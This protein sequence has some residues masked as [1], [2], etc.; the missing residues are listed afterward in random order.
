MSNFTR[1]THVVR[2]FDDD[3]AQFVDVEVLDAIAFRID[4]G[5][6]VVLSMEQSNSQPYIVDDTGGEHGQKPKDPTQRTHMKRI[7]AKNDATQMLD[8]EVM[9]IM[10]FNDQNGGQWILDMKATT[11]E[12]PDIFDT[13]TST[14][15]KASTRRGHDEKIAITPGEKNPSLYV[16]SQRCDAIAFRTIMGQEV[17]FSCPSSDDPNSS[18]P[19]AKTFIV[20][21]TGYDPA[22]DS[23]VPP[24]NKDPHNY[25]KFV[26]GANGFITG[27]TPISMG[28]FWWIRKISGGDIFVVQIDITTQNNVFST[29]DTPP[30][31]FLTGM[32][33]SYGGPQ[34]I[35]NIVA[36]SVE[37]PLTEQDGFTPLPIMPIDGKVKPQIDLKKDDLWWTGNA[38]DPTGLTTENWTVLLFFNTKKIQKASSDGDLHI[39]LRFPA[40]RKPNNAQSGI[41][42]FIWAYSGGDASS[43]IHPPP[44][45]T[46]AFLPY[47]FNDAVVPNY[48]GLWNNFDTRIHD[49]ASMKL[50]NPQLF[51]QLTQGGW[52][53]VDFP[54]TALGFHT[55]AGAQAYAT[56]LIV[57]QEI[58]IEQ[59]IE[60]AARFGFTF[61][62]TPVIN[63]G[64]LILDFSTPN[65]VAPGTNPI[66]T[67]KI[68][69]MNFSGKTTFDYDDV[70]TPLFK[71]PTDPAPPGQPR[72]KVLNVSHTGDF[73]GSSIVVSLSA[74][75]VITINEN[76][77]SSFAVYS[78]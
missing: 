57:S 17:I 39:D 7:T 40:I 22:D 67:T 37:G 3:K 75:G 19:R 52:D 48:I 41:G 10:A 8:V 53:F 1:R 47:P 29:P 49:A 64:P 59:A 62:P 35:D 71:P 74:K 31:L 61:N 21:P 43:L 36:P 73:N 14:G 26:K 24:D 65:T 54:D 56:A 28:P 12:G 4:G 55:A 51:A 11:G 34:G 46:N 68:T 6:E 69:A 60:T 16:T 72:S 70:N 5:K 2:C 13:T 50:L 44:D 45:V 38:F 23:I 66:I 9:D 30:A 77:N 25:V 42:N 18:S 78:P 27:D 20:S 32:R 58:S 76:V 63:F 33:F 15:S